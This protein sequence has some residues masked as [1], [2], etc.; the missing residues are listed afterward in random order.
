M[1]LPALLTIQT[2]IN[3]P[4]Y[5]N[6]RAIKQAKE[7]PLELL[8]PGEVGLDGAALEAAAGSRTR[9]VAP[10]EA[11]GGAEMLSGS[12]SEVAQR[13]ADIVKEKMTG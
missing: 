7:K 10:P 5:A 11:A 9:S 1:R 8:E 6:L 13:I 3:E 12:A 4:R 2:G